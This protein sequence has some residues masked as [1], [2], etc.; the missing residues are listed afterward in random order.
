MMSFSLNQTGYVLGFEE[1]VQIGSRLAPVVPCVTEKQVVRLGSRSYRLDLVAIAVQ[2]RN[3]FR[4]VGNGRGC[5]RPSRACGS[6]TTASAGETATPRGRGG[7]RVVRRRRVVRPVR[8]PSPTRGAVGG[9][10]RRAVTFARS[11]ALGHVSRLRATTD[12][13]ADSGCWGRDPASD[14][15]PAALLTDQSG[16]SSFDDTGRSVMT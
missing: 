15:R 12:I 3:F 16:P 9:T 8:R 10:A 11:C 2:R 14:W 1:V 13:H 7:R 4:G 5:R 6:A